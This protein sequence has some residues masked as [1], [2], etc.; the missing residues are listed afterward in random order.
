MTL[1]ATLGERFPRVGGLLV[2]GSVGT[3]AAQKVVDA[4]AGLDV[5]ACLRVDAELVGRLGSMD[6]ARVTSEARRVAARVAAD[7]VAAHAESTM[8]GRCVEVRAGWTG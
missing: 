3:I 7:Q 5:D 4:C 1:G 2:E 6:P 8:R